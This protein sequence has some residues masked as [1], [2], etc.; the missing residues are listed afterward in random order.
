MIINLPLAVYL[1][2][3]IQT[4][5]YLN[6]INVTMPSN[7]NNFLEIFRVNIFNFLDYG[8]ASESKLQCVAPNR[9]GIEEF[10]CSILNNNFL[11]LVQ[12]LALI[13]LKFAISLAAKVSN[14]KRVQVT[15]DPNS[16]VNLG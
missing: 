1:M 4:I 8:P 16:I 7:L 10:S 13:L 15:P 12:I 2:K 14:K 11:M 9:F 3:L 5:S 6:L